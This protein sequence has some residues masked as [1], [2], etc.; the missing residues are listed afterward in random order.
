MPPV[1]RRKSIVLVVEDDPSLR[2]MYRSALTLAGYIAIAV[3]DGIEA[4]RHLEAD[5]PGL[6]VLDLGLPRLSGMDVQREMAA[7]V[8]TQDIPI[9]VVTGETGDFNPADFAC[10]LRKPIDPHDLL[11]A[12]QKCLRRQGRKRR[13]K[14]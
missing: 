3:E 8:E 13:P 6:V 5:S 10:V 2:Q 7:H 9:V 4:L 12:V 11:V 14:T 1:H